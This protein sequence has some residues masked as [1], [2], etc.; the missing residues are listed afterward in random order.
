MYR[1]ADRLLYVEANADAD[2]II[3]SDSI[4]WWHF[5]EPRVKVTDDE[6]ALVLQRLVTYLRSQGTDVKIR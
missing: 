3:Y 6:R 2:C 5:P 1:E 4:K